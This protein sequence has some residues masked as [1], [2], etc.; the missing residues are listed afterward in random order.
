MSQGGIGY[1]DTMPLL[2]SA[3]GF[4]PA[5]GEDSDDPG[6]DDQAVEEGVAAAASDDWLGIF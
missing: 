2:A 5:G 1:G 4:G 3:L 6:L